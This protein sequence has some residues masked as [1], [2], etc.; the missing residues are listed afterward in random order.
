MESIFATARLQPL[1][2]KINEFVQTELLPLE[3][4]RHQRPFA[5]TARILEKKREKI[6]SAGLWGL[7]LPKNEG[8]IGLTLCEFG[9]L[10]EAMARA[11]LY[12]HY[13]FNCQAPDIG[14]MELLSKFA[15]PEIKE[16][17]LRPLLE[18]KTRSCFSMTEPGFAG[19]NPVRM[20]T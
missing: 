3:K 16:R 19:S 13:A 17:F 8:G 20:A 6:K 1:I 7:H 12:G 2:E 11:P 15:S 10:S 9:Q 5:E 4:E 14:N 18:G